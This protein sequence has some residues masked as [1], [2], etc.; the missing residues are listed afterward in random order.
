MTTLLRRRGV[1]TVAMIE[2]MLPREMRKA[3]AEVEWQQASINMDGEI[4]RNRTKS[5]REKLREEYKKVR[6]TNVE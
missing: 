6:E 1:A 2:K 5:L 3:V 4:E